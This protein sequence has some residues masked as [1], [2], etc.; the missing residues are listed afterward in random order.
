MLSAVPTFAYGGATIN[1]QT[2]K[3]WDLAPQSDSERF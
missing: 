3:A 2:S 1:G